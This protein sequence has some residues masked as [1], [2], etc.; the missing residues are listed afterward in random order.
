[1]SAFFAAA[2]HSHHP[3]EDN[4]AWGA[5]IIADP[6][7]LH[8][9]YFQN[10]DGLRNDV[11][12]IE[13]YVSSMAQLQIGTFCWADPGLDFSKP[14]VRQSLQRPIRKQFC[15]ARSSFSSS[16]S[17]LMLILPLALADVNQVALLWQRLVGGLLEVLALLLWIARASADGQVYAIW[18]NVVSASPS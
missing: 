2:Q 13:L 9:I 11:D 17:L 5:S 12:E 10:I 18:A 15:S 3:Q 6:G 4:S 16:K 7:E 8:R 1:M 14:T